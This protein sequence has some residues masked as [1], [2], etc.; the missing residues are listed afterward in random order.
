MDSTTRPATA[1]S[2]VDSYWAATAGPEFDGIH[3]LAADESVEV[4]VIGAGYAGLCAAYH[5]AGSHGIEAVVLE[6][7]RIGW[8]ASG[9]NGGI[10]SITLGKVPLATRIAEWGV[11]AT[12]RA[13]EIGVDAVERVR[14]LIA[15]EGIACDPTPDGY[16]H[17]AHHP[18]RVAELRARLALYR[19][20]LRYDGVEFLDRERLAR[21][22]H[23]RGP[24]AHGALR[25]RDVFGLHPLKYARGLARA[26]VRRG[27]VLH[28]RSPVVGWRR[29][30][31]YHFLAT[32]GGTIRA[33]QVIV[34]TNGYTPERLQPWLRGRLLPTTSNI[35]VT[36]PLTD[37]EWR[38]VGTLR[39]QCY[40]DTR[41]LL[42]YWRRLPDGRM[43]FGGRAGLVN[44]GAALRRRRRW[45][46][47]RMAAKF[48]V[49][50]GV[51]SEYFWHGNVCLSYDLMPHVGFA[52]DDPS[53]VYALAYLGNGVSIAT[54]SGGLAADLAAGKEV[55]RDTPLTGAG[56]PRFPLPFLRRL[57]IAGAY[58]V[59]GIK[60][61]WPVG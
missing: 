27:A 40:S 35:V 11:A 26:A 15:T 36:R 34:A 58:L 39:V 24:A 48:P 32:P 50:A 23:L 3:P 10:C 14:H 60:D 21:E 9:R 13:L 56:L 43:L 2:H 18:A 44:T 47:D 52:G 22:G 12:R 51:G 16:V 29:E 17:V 53:V 6:A 41:N 28:D 55:P 19:E 45:L 59:Y 42:F 61:R 33:R 5:L 46:E 7:H 31:R 25:F 57:Y 20:A 54:Y 1:A 38:D 8:G 37:G 30:G 4:A 49:L